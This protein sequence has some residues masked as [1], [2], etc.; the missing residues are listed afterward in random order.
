MPA[1][2]ALKQ[3]FDRA[4]FLAWEAEQPDRWEFLGGVVEMMAGGRVDHNIVAGNLFFALRLR[5]RG[6]PCMP[7]QQNM[8]LT[9]AETE[10][11]TYPDILVTCRPVAGNRPS[12]ATATC[13]VEVLS[14]GTREKDASRKWDSYQKI[15]DLRHYALVDPERPRIALY[16]R[17]DENAVWIFRVIEGLDAELPLP[18]CGVV[19]PFREIYADTEAGRESH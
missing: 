10:D 1:G 13:L 9:P 18:A 15:V 8:K 11:S 12:V 4:A 16:S 2:L 3:P 14:P 6:G 17:A 5:L 7:F 19:I